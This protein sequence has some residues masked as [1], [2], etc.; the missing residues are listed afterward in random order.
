MTFHRFSRRFHRFNK[1]LLQF[2]GLDF[3]RGIRR[4]LVCL[5]V[6]LALLS[7]P[8]SNSAVEQMPVLASSAVSTTAEIAAN[9]FG[10]ISRFLKSIFGSKP[11]KPQRD[12]LVDRLAGVSRLRVSPLKQLGY[13]G[14]TVIF[15]AVPTDFYGRTLP[16]VKFDWESSNTSLLQ[17]DDA[18]R[19]RLLQPGL[20]T[21]S[22]RA[23]SAVGAA[24]VLIRSGSRPAQT[25][26][27]WRADQ[28]SVSTTGLTTG[29]SGSGGSQ[30]LDG[31]GGEASEAE[32]PTRP[33]GKIES[34]SLNEA[35]QPS[36]SALTS[37]GESLGSGS[38]STANGLTG[39]GEFLSSVFDRLFP[40]AYA[41]GSGGYW[42]TDFPYDEL[43]SQPR[44][45][46]GSPR[47]GVIEPTRIGSVIPEASNFNMGIPIASVGGRGL[48][49]GVSLS[50]NSRVWARHGTAVTWD[51]ISTWP[52]PGFS[53]GFGRI[54]AY[55]PTNA[56]QYILIDPSG[57]RRYLGV[58]TARGEVVTLKTNDGTNIVYVG[59]AYGGTVYYPGGPRAVF[60]L[61]NNRTVA[62]QVTDINGNYI[63][64]TYLGVTCDAACAPCDCPIFWPPLAIDHV[65]DSLGRIIQFNYDANQNLTSITAPGLGGTVQNPIT[66]IVAQFDYESRSVSGN[67]SGLTVENRPTSN[68]NFLKHVYFPATQTGVLFNYT[69]FGTAYN[70][71]TRRQMTINNGVI[72]D[73]L[74]N[75]SVAFNYQQGSTPAL[76]EAPAF[77]TRTET[78]GGTF[79]YSS[80]DDGVAQTKTMIVTLPDTTQQQ[81]VASELRLTRSTSGAALSKRVL[82]QSEIKRGSTSYAKAVYNYANDPGGSPQVQSI[83]AYNDLNQAGKVDF[84]YDANGNVLNKREYGFQSGGVWNVQR[85]THLTYKTDTAYINEYLR[86]L[87]TQIEIL[88]ALNDSND[89]NDV[90]VA[91]SATI[92]DDYGGTMGGLEDYST[93]PGPNPAAP[94]GHLSSYDVTKTVRGNAT[95][96]TE[97]S[98]IAG[99]LSVTRLN[100]R[101]IFGN[102]VKAQV[103]CCSEK[104][105]TFTEATYWSSPEDVTSGV[106]SGVHLTSSADYDFDTGV[107]NT[108]TDPN[109]QTTSFTYDAALRNT[110][111]TIPTGA[112][113]G[114]NFFDSTLSSSSY[115]DYWEDNIHKIIS[116]STVRDGWG[117][118]IQVVNPHMGQ[119]NRTYNAMGLVQSQTIR[120]QAGG[121]PGPASTSQYDSL[122]RVTVVT[123]PDGNTMQN[124]YV[125]S[126]VTATDPVGRKIKRESDSLGRLVKVTEQDA[127]G[128][129]TQ[130]TTYSYDVLDNLTQ[131]NQGGQFR[132]YKYDALG[133]LLYE[134]IPE[135]SATLWDGVGAYWSM[136]YTYTDFDAV[137]TRTDAR[138]VVTTYTYDGLHRLTQIS[139]NVPGGVAT[140]PTVTY[141]FDTNSSS[142]TNGQ[143]LSVGVGTGYQESNTYS[144]FTRLAST[145]H[146]VD[147]RNYTT[148]YDYN[149]V[150]QRKQVGHMYFQFDNMGHLFA[151]KNFPVGGNGVSYLTNAAYDISGLLVS[152][153][154]STNGTLVNET[155]VF[156]PLRSEVASMTAVRGGTTLMSLQ[157]SY[158]AQAGQ[159]G[160]LTTAGNPG[161]V[162]LASGTINGASESGS[163]SYDLQQRLTTASIAT[164]GASAQRRF[165]YD[166]WG[167]GQEYGTQLAMAVRSR[168]QHW[169]NL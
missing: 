109:N 78:P 35:S 153:S 145:T 157:F 29:G 100:K 16:G 55:G 141:T 121:Q 28:A 86:N 126:S 102:V 62:M 122:G 159:S 68:V 47:N 67:F 27:Q 98:D 87:V 123:L 165:V 71:S 58:G 133:R 63:T 3:H 142:S 158:Q 124:Q 120:F 127:V 37:V 54:V 51:A 48:G 95:G 119:I 70:V 19:A 136:K 97:W 69:A 40:T 39:T 169:S 12:R 74:E 76:T 113:G 160:A 150:N 57:T 90:V 156:D 103:S 166:R 161:Q 22:C 93:L 81:P 96:T 23:G 10:A 11:A 66:Q 79:S 7:S 101:D 94:P 42:G 117:R 44:N 25:D 132:S 52:G 89:G 31:R 85:R 131:V 104:S 155:N 15:G 99:N 61:V 60:G 14:E 140:T 152:D 128:A 143:L 77:T 32:T 5:A 162:M 56:T 59:S 148:D 43:W 49:A 30:G 146:T 137:A 105:F 111:V 130:E 149:E 2:P 53:M 24:R 21:V 36:E 20:V 8:V 45:L 41:Q 106:S 116:S 134:R 65:T 144:S 114:M 1:H 112:V 34:Q 147:G 88:D 33:E 125:G 73:G 115:K 46:V 83:I 164:N 129:L 91:K 168:A 84:D 18:G 38:A 9:S 72:S 26:A 108:Q 107:T 80:V 13:T 75:A 92:Y 50:Y 163:Y 6:M 151:V 17:I 135:K 118:T 138:G 64:I 4:K 139:Y 110:A 154:L 167:I 82:T